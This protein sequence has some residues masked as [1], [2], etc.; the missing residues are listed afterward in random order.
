MNVSP[1]VWKIKR[2]LNIG[3]EKELRRSIKNINLLAKEVIRQ[4]REIGFSD[5]KDLLSRFM[6]KVFDE[7]LLRDIIVSFILAGRDTVAAALTGFF[8]LVGN[9]PIVE[10]AILDEAV[11][12]IGPTRKPTGFEQLRELHYLQ[13]ALYESMRLFPPVQ[14]DSKFCQDDDVLPD[15]SI[16]KKGTRVTY[17]PYAMG[18]MEEIWGPDCLEYKPERWLKDGVFFQENSFKYPIFQGGCRICLGKEIAL[19]EITSIILSVLQKFRVELQSEEDLVE[20]DGQQSG[21]QIVNGQMVS[22]PFGGVPNGGMHSRWSG[23]LRG[24]SGIADGVTSQT[25]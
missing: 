20:S 16:I 4:R 6:L 13:A 2:A 8:F 1:S 18:R 15:G 17:H 21:R 19:I 22:R 11:R 25:E 9:H 7:N 12:V 23:K 10:A 3:S 5:K 24:R 14:L